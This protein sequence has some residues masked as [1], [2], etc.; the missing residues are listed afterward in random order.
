MK[1]E[2]DRLRKEASEWRKEKADAYKD[3][4]KTSAVGLEVGLSIVVGIS[5][6]FFVD[7]YF[8]CEPWGIVGGF[9][10]GAAAAGKRLYSFSKKYLKDNPPDDHR[11][12]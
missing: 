1:Q 11:P 3:Y 8:H 12:H 7:R 2:R 10:I 4:I 9:I 6:G 5:A